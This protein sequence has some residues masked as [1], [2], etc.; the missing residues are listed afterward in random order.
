MYKLTSPTYKLCE[1][2]ALCVQNMRSQRKQLFQNLC[3]DMEEAERELEV[4]VQNGKIHNFPYD[5]HQIYAATNE[6][7]IS[8]YE[9]YL[10]AENSGREVYE[11]IFTLAQ[12]KFCPYCEHG[13]VR[14]VDHFL[15]KSMYPILSVSPLNLI[16]VC[17]DCNRIKLDQYPILQEGAFLHPFFEETG[18]DIWL[19]AEIEQGP[20]FAFIFHVTN[21]GNWSSV[22]FERVKFQFKELELAILYGAQASDWLS[23]DIEMLFKLYQAGGSSLLKA[24]LLELAQDRVN[25]KRGGRYKVWQIPVLLGLANNVWFCAGGVQQVMDAL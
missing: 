19:S 9:D 13:F 4:C 20:P 7:I 17:R 6:Q 22:F 14:E 8:L 5:K 12:N 1:V 24:H 23:G 15:P 2:I 25:V 16:P 3:S 21:P 10:L 18:T 11:H